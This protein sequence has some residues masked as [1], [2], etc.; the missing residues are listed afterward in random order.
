MAEIGLKEGVPVSSAVMRFPAGCI[1]G[2]RERLASIFVKK[3]SSEAIAKAILDNS[4]DDKVFKWAG[5][6]TPLDAP[7]KSVEQRKQEIGDTQG[8]T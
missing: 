2:E 5:P 6:E 8:H 1:K 3:K 7:P 4:L